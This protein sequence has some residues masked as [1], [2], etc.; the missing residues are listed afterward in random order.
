MKKATINALDE[1]GNILIYVRKKD[2]NGNI[3]LE[4]YWGDADEITIW[5]RSTTKA[6]REGFKKHF[7]AEQ[8]QSYS[9]SIAMGFPW[10]NRHRRSRQ[11]R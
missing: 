5:L 2:A 1:T 6:E 4:N 7:S 3:R 9:A 11:E 8:S 10:T